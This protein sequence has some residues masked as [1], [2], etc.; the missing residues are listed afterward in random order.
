MASF[1]RQVFETSSETCIFCS[2]IQ[3][4]VS[5]KQSVGSA[6]EVLAES[7]KTVFDE[8]HFILIVNL[9]NFLQSLDLPRHTFPLS[10]SFVPH[11]PRQNNF[12]NFSP[13]DTSETALVCIF[14]SILNHR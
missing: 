4:I 1:L 12:Q 13:V 7:L 8:A 2:A 3:Y 6:H 11:P 10:E 5:K 9:H 14:S